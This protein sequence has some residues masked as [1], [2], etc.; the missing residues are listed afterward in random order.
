MQAMSE[1]DPTKQ[2]MVHDT[3]TG[4][5]FA[6]QPEWAEKEG[7]GYTERRGTGADA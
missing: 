4:Q 3:L 7:V 6:W 2:A 5:D 1:F